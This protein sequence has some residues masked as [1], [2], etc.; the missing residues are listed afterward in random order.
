MNEPV[1][2]HVN[3]TWQV[4]AKCCKIFEPGGAAGPRGALMGCNL[5][6]RCCAVST[7]SSLGLA[8][9]AAQWPVWNE[10]LV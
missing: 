10:P 3:E 8:L 5:A 7:K 6:F 9:A 2:L 1:S 4:C